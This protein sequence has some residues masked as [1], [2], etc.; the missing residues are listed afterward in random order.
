MSIALPQGWSDNS[1]PDAM[2]FANPANREELIV[3][4]RWITQPVDIAQLAKIVEELTH[5]RLTVL[6]Q[7]SAGKFTV[8]E[9]EQF[10]SKASSGFHF[11]GLDTKNLVYSKGVVVGFFSHVVSIH[12]YLHR[13]SA[14]SAEIVARADI[15]MCRSKASP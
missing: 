3:S 14:V 1:D 4:L 7:V 8:L 12:Y 9:G 11:S 5:H 6:A 10:T 15:D 13:C 2:A